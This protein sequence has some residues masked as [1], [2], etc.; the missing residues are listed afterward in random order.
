MHKHVFDQFTRNA[1]DALTRRRSLVTLGG[2]VLAT[3]IAAPPRAHAGKNSKKAKKQAK[4]KCKRQVEAC[5]NVFIDACAT[6]PD[7]CEEGDLEEVF[8]YCELLKDCKAGESVACFFDLVIP[9]P[10]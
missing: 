9:V 8:P 2:A 6:N 10:Q 7:A 5:R 3:S 4:K 1:T